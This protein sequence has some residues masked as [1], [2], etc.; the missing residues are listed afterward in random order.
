MKTGPY[1]ALAAGGS[2]LTAI[3]VGLLVGWML[4]AVAFSG[5]YDTSVKTPPCTVNAHQ[6]GCPSWPHDMR[7][8]DGGR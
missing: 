6:E 7:A 2:A 4:G 1:V 3:G 5:C 8:P